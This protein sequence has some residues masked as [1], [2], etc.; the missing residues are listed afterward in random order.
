MKLFYFYLFI[1]FTFFFSSFHTIFAVSTALVPVDCSIITTLRVFSKGAE[2]ECLQKKI[3]VVAD[4]SFGPLTKAAVL[5]FQ[6]S[7]GLVADGV[8][9]TR[10]RAVLNN[11]VI[12]NNTVY[13]SGCT[14]AVGYS[15]TTG[16]KCD[17]S[18]KPLTV[19]NVVKN[20]ENI[21]ETPPV[22][23]K[24]SSNLVNLDKFIARIV[25][26][27]RKDGKNEEELT[28]I[29]STIRKEIINSN[30]DYN[31]EFWEMLTKESKL[32][33]NF[34][35]PSSLSFLGKIFSKTFSF[36][37][38]T[39]SVVEASGALPFGG[40]LLS[41]YRCKNGFLTLFIEPLPPTNVAL[42]SYFPFTQGFASYNIPKTSWLLGYYSPRGICV[43]NYYPYASYNTEGTITPMVGSSPI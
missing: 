27:N 34:K 42:L 17:G 38:I 32:S 18:P 10:T 29:A 8:V 6:S 28:L 9:G 19:N 15:T 5:A 43:V 4:G 41:S 24:I 3:G 20:S 12:A 35:T 11:G 21:N 31:K 33:N 23:P 13:P 30:I 22:T 40:A 7:N 26:V 2:V 25:D 37:G 14:S 1:I 39:P 16:S 36:L